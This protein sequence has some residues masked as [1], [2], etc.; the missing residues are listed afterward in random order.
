MNG[1]VL[2][3]VARKDRAHSRRAV[4]VKAPA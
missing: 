1:V 2:P 3:V 4:S